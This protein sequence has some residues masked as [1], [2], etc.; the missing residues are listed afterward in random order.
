MA[1]AV[2]VR[3]GEGVG[4]G[5][6]NVVTSADDRKVACEGDETATGDVGNAERLASINGAVETDSAAD[7]LDSPLVDEEEEMVGED[8]DKDK[9]EGATDN[10]CV[11]KPGMASSD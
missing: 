10:E 11:G 8:K 6:L 3:V 4:E 7:K 1:T 9:R 5:V 2:G